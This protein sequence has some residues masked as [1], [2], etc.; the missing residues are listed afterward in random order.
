MRS[1]SLSFLTKRA[2][3]SGQLFFA[4]LLGALCALAIPNLVRDRR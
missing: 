2:G 1:K 3:S 4:Q